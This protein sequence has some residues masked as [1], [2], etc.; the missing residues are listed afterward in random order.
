MPL[1]YPL[2]SEAARKANQ[3]A[4]NGSVQHLARSSR[5]VDASWSSPP[6]G[7]DRLM[8]VLCPR[9]ALVREICGWRRVDS[10]SRAAPRDSEQQSLRWLEGARYGAL[11]V[12]GNG[13]EFGS[14]AP[15][16][17]RQR[18]VIIAF[19]MQWFHPAWKATA[20]G[21]LSAQVVRGPRHGRTQ[22]RT[23]R[24]DRFP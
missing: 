20:H 5:P 6:G 2:E 9:L 19:H 23:G 16:I 14:I 3:I 22:T 8:V 24:C 15:L 13:R 10:R 11:M 1:Y 18:L 21:F 7:L 4:R 17:T 12:H